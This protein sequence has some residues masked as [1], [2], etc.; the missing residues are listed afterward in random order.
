MMRIAW[1]PAAVIWVGAAVAAGAPSPDEQAVRGVAE[2]F[3]KAYNSGDAAGVAA[4]FTPEAEIIDEEGHRSEGRQAIEKVFAEIFRASPGGRI[5]IAIESIRFLMPT[6]AIEDGIASVI[7]AGGEPAERTRY[8]V[9]H[10]KREGRWLMA[11]ARDLPECPST[12]SEELKQL[13]WLIGEW[14]DESPDSLVLASYHWADNHNYI[15]NEFKVQIGGR[16]AM[17][18]SQRIGWDPLRKQLRSWAFDSEGGFGEGR[19]TRDGQRWVVKFTAVTRDG[20]TASA[21]N[22]TTRVSSDRMTWQ[23]RDRIVGGKAMPDVEPIPIVRK[24]PQPR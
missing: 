24:P 15:L 9:V 14:V 16:P 8:T 2:T 20:K 19:W 21:T 6:V 22:I 4:L 11:S 17:I 18:G 1:I 23:S 3:A 5:E 12:S 10:V 13:A 7:G